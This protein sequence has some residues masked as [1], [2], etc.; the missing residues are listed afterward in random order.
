[1]S[2]TWEKAKL[3]FKVGAIAGAVLGG[4]G[5]AP[6]GLLGVVIGAAGGAIGWGIAGAVV[7]GAYGAVTN[8]APEKPA[9][10]TEV[11]RAPSKAAEQDMSPDLATTR[12]QDMVNQ[13]RAQQQA[14][15]R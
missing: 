14:T 5:G 9:P 10:H 6:L 13:S 4:V 12:Y 15:S 7:G 2:R 8:D 11:T 3:G 1:M